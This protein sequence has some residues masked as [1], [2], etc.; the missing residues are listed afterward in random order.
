MGECH[1][2]GGREFTT[3]VAGST[4]VGGRG[5]FGTTGRWAS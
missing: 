5:V 1:G 4:E 3:E 2:K